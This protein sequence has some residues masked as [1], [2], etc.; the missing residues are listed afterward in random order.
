[1]GRETVKT[2]L[3]SVY[4]KT[5]AANRSQLAAAIARDALLG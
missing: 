4:T 5:G 2:H 3:S 1:M